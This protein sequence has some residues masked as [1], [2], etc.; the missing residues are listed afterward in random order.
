MVLLAVT[1]W[2]LVAA[3][4]TLALLGYPRRAPAPVRPALRWMLTGGL[5]IETSAV[6]G[7]I[8]HEQDWTRIHHAVGAAELLLSLTGLACLGTATVSWR[9]R[10]SVT[11]DQASAPPSA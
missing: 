7:L 8:A 6:L 9:R 11:P 5:L 10:S 3:L 1:C 2:F 4:L